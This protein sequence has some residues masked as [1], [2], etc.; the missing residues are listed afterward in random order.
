MNS[1]KNISYDL[2]EYILFA[3]YPFPGFDCIFKYIKIFFE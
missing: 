3:G 2:Y 1:K